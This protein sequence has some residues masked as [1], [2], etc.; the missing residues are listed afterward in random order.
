MWTSINANYRNMEN[1][2]ECGEQRKSSDT[3]PLSWDFLQSLGVRR[4]IKMVDGYHRQLLVF[5]FNFLPY[6]SLLFYLIFLFI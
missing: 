5:N 6:I 3:I 1:G 4:T 2:E